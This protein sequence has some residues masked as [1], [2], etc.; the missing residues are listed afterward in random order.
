MMTSIETG[1]EVERTSESNYHFRL[2]SLKDRLLELY[3]QNEDFVYPRIRMDEVVA[4]V[5]QGL[6]D[7]SISRPVERLSWGVRV[8]GDDSQTIYVWLD[9]LINYL[10]K[11]GFPWTPGHESAGGWPADVHVVGKDI[12][13]FHCIYWP[14]FLMALD[15][16]P[17]RQVLTHAHWTLGHRKMAKSTG[18]VVNPFFAIDRFGTETMRFY[19][20]HDGGLEKDAN[21]DNEHIIT[22]YKKC[23]QGGL[24]NLAS[25][26]TRGK[27]WSVRA[28][29]QAAFDSSTAQETN[30]NGSSSAAQRQLLHRLPQVTEEQMDRP[31]V[32]AAL[33]TIMD[34]IFQTNAYL[35]D[36][37]PWTNIVNGSVKEEKKKSIGHVNET[38]YLCAEALR[39]SGILL[40]PCIPEKAAQLLNTLGVGTDR[41]SLA[42]AKLG[43][44]EAYGQST[45]QLGR[46]HEGVLFPPLRSDE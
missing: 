25:R 33:K 1:K 45:L 32:S 22:R 41:R 2:S 7:L 38:V 19:L 10:T 6:Q 3:K 23:L 9:A 15:I 42:W 35:Q 30:V 16:E 26:I 29:V 4:N 37:S 20:A 44:D 46:G 12:V 43:A 8:P 13:R 27:G 11:S 40:Q 17:P 31:D 14:A 36:R 34:A 5:T 39:I 24:G 18:N 28:A 21:Y